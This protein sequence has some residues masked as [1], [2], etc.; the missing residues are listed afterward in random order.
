M[1][2][3]LNGKRPEML[4]NALQCTGRPH[5]KDHLAS[6]VSSEKAEKCCFKGSMIPFV[7]RLIFLDHW[8]T[9]PQK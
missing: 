4:L 8:L 6:N 1:L 7:K 2:L 9:P 5:N 3:A